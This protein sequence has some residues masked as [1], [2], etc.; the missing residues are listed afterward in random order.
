MFWLSLTSFMFE[1]NNLASFGKD[2]LRL[3]QAGNQAANCEAL[4]LNTLRST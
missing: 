3:Y 4:P 1:L 2:L